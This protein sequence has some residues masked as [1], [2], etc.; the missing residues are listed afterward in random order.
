MLVVRKAMA[1]ESKA[2]LALLL[3]LS[4]CG[5]Q[6]PLPVFRERPNNLLGRRCVVVVHSDP[7]FVSGKLENLDAQRVRGFL[8]A[9]AFRTWRV[10]LAEPDCSALAFNHGKGVDGLINLSLFRNG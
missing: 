8:G 4:N 3:P 7:A 1:D 6:P 9:P 2:P 5:L 10:G